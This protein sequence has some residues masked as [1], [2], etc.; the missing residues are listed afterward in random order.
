M[1]SFLESPRKTRPWGTPQECV[2]EG[3]EAL[4][5]SLSPYPGLMGVS[6]V[7]LGMRAPRLNS[8]APSGTK[9]DR[10]CEQRKTSFSRA[11]LMFP[12]IYHSGECYITF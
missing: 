11:F 12:K 2:I 8:L 7:H 6:P 4:P 10:K 9:I 1:A 3:G 5:H